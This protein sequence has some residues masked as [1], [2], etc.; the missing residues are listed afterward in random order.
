[1]PHDSPLI[2]TIVGGIGLA[3]VLGTTANRLRVSPLVG[4]LL[5][6]VLV[7]PFTPGFVA[8]E[9]LAAQLAEIGVLL[10]MFG[11][12]LH[13]SLKDLMS[14]R[15]VVIVVDPPPSRPGDLDPGPRPERPRLKMNDFTIE[16]VDQVLATAAPKGLLM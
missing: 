11:V 2:A 9:A 12:G 6:G 16:K 3:F 5:A 13:F 10:L 15:A 4:Y 7:G 14:I 1:M 8:D